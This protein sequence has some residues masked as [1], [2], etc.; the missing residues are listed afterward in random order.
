VVDLGNGNRMTA[1][2]FL[3]YFLFPPETQYNFVEKL[4]GG[5]KRRLYLC[6]I[7]MRNPNFLILDEPTNDLDIMTLNV[8]EDYLRNF[9]GC[10][11]VVSHDRFFMDKIVD[12]LFVFQGEGEIKDFPGNYSDYREWIEEQEKELRTPEKREKVAKPKQ[13]KEGTRK[14]SFNEKRELEQLEKEITMLEEEKRVIETA[15]NSGDCPSEELVIK[16]QRHG[17][18]REILDGK[19][20]RWM[21]LSEE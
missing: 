12:H 1:S 10:A 9:Q 8:L 21:E 2:Q 3:N 6:T 20:L 7:L 17:E 13:V 15:M 16:S 18:I 4:S 11:I 14:L 5:E 19:E